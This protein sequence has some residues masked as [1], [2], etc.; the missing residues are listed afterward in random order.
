MLDLSWFDHFMH[1]L[2]TLVACWT[3]GENFDYNTSTQTMGCFISGVFQLFPNTAIRQHGNLF[4]QMDPSVVY[5]LTDA[6]PRWFRVFPK[7]LEIMQNDPEGFFDICLQTT[8]SLFNWLYLFKVYITHTLNKQG[9]YLELPTLNA[10][11]S[12]YDPKTITKTDWGRPTWY[13]IH[14]TALFC[15]GGHDH[16]KVF[17]DMLHCLQYV[18]P[19]PKCRAHLSQNLQYID[20]SNCGGHTNSNYNVELFKCTWNL[21]NIVNKSIDKSIMSF[22]DALRIYS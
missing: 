22:K 8:D 7:Y 15:P 17:H 6:I 18:L 10:L 4:M 1:C 13:V 16:F 11:K 12:Q 5:T 21:H 3:P 20:F 9:H 19:C 2:F 14:T